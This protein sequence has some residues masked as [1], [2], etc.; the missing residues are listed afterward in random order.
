MGTQLLQRVKPHDGVLRSLHMVL[1][2]AILVLILTGSVMDYF[3][4]G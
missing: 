1:G 4:N 2:V 3:A